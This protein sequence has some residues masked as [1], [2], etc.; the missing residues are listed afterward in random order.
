MHLV[1]NNYN[2]ELKSHLEVPDKENQ[3]SVS[4]SIATLTEVTF[5]SEESFLLD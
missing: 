2:K 1:Q 5:E 3:T 4:N